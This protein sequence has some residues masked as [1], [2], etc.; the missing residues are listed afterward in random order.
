MLLAFWQVLHSLFFFN[1]RLLLRQ[2]KSSP[3][4][5]LVNQVT[6]R[7]RQLCSSSSG[8][9][10]ILSCALTCIVCLGES[11]ISP[12]RIR[13]RVLLDG[14]RQRQRKVANQFNTPRAEHTNATALSKLAICNFL[15]KLFCLHKRG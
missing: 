8:L 12:S 6:G 10:C 2:K 1:F 15:V 9:L 14:G 13:R 5:F 7:L 3:L 4:L 11:G